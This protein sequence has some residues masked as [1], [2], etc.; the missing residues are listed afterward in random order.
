MK[1]NYR[2]AG[3]EDTRKIAEFLATNGELLLPMVELIESSRMAVGELVDLLGRASIE[4]VLRLSAQG[5]A[6]EKPCDIPEAPGAGE[7]SPAS[8]N[9]SP[10][11]AASFACSSP[12]AAPHNESFSIHPFRHT[13]FPPLERVSSETTIGPA[14]T[15]H[16][17]E[18]WLMCRRFQ[19]PPLPPR[20]WT[21][22]YIQ[23]RIRFAPC[24]SRGISMARLPIAFSPR[25][26]PYPVEGRFPASLRRPRRAVLVTYILSLYG[27]ARCGME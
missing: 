23:H 1:K 18:N 13:P 3:K 9:A 15:P 8:S 16:F 22:F 27:C 7:L 25:E 17:R 2:I 6:G 11:L 10:F 24:T 5:V 19:P 14:F 26:A 4:A 21:A 12:R 20:F